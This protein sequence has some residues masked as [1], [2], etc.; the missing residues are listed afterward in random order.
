VS[1][2][3]LI[4]TCKSL[5]SVFAVKHPISALLLLASDLKCMQL[6]IMK[7]TDLKLTM[8]LCLFKLTMEFQEGS[9]LIV[10][11]T[12]FEIQTLE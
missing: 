11:E 8:E 4:I 2:S 9:F 5:Q 7:Y 12:H 10:F 6:L 3:V 1:C